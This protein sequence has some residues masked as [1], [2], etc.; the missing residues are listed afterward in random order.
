MSRQLLRPLDKPVS[1]LDINHCLRLRPSEQNMPRSPA[2]HQNPVPISNQVREPDH[3][4]GYKLID[5]VPASGP[6]IKSAADTRPATCEHQSWPHRV[7]STVQVPWPVAIRALSQFTW[8]SV[9][10]CIPP[11]DFPV[12]FSPSEQ[13]RRLGALIRKLKLGERSWLARSQLPSPAL[14]LPVG[15]EV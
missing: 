11:P 13:P 12:F 6:A 3:R 8:N 7:P 10:H 5:L 4:Y 14:P 2:R 15:S 9:H 1:N